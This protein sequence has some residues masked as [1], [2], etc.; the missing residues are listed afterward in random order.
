MRKAPETPDAVHLARRLARLDTGRFPGR[1]GVPRGSVFRVDIHRR[2]LRQKAHTSRRP[3]RRAFVTTIA[4]RR[5]P[6]RP[7]ISR[8]CSRSSSLETRLADMDQDGID[9]Q[10]VSPSPDQ[11]VGPPG[12]PPA[13]EA[14][15][16]VNDNIADICGKHPDRFSAGSWSALFQAPE[17]A[18]RRSRTASI[19]RSA[20]AIPRSPARSGWRSLHA[21]KYWPIFQK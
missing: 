18:R 8:G 3:I 21:E 1:R 4:P 15:R 14:T 10:A 20:C 13:I 5:P 12:R 16:L 17:L 9:V 11:T 19:N 6:P 7:S 2:L